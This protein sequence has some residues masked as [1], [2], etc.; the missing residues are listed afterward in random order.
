MV[1]I[2]MIFEG[3]PASIGWWECWVAC[4]SGVVGKK[5]KRRII[6]SYFNRINCKIKSEM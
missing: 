5:Y 2:A 4:D 3:L 1:V 6:L